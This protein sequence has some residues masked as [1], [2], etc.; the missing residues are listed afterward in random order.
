MD[1]SSSMRGEQRLYL[2]AYVNTA[3]KWADF[4]NAWKVALT[5]FPAIDYFKTSEAYSRRGQ[6]LGWTPEARD[7]KIMALAR[8]VEASSPWGMHTS[9]DTLVWKRHM[10]GVAPYGFAQPYFPVFH[11]I[12][13]NVARVHAGLAVDAPVDFIFDEQ[14]GTGRTAA[15]FVDWAMGGWPAEQQAVIGNPPTFAD[16]KRV[17]PLQAADML[18]WHVRREGEN[19][20]AEPNQS[21]FQM[22]IPDGRHFMTH[23]DEGSIERMAASFRQMPGVAQMI[24]KGGWMKARRAIQDAMA[25]GWKPPEEWR[26]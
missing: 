14:E 4:S 15:M 8:V 19:R 13:A 17:L 5:S 9:V 11:G 10:A 25:L 21:V 6:F 3:E 18:A 24:E 2:C 1:D 12:L 26:S 7:A 22:L 16:D 20:P 23:L